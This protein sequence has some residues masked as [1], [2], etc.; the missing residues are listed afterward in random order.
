MDSCA[1]GHSITS[2]PFINDLSSGQRKTEK[3][4]DWL[5]LFR[6]AQCP[7]AWRKGERWKSL[8]F[9]P[10]PRHGSLRWVD[11]QVCTMMLF[12][13]FAFYFLLIL[14]WLICNSHI[15]R[16]NPHFNV[17]VWYCSNGMQTC[18]AAWGKW[19][20]IWRKIDPT[21]T[22]PRTSATAPGGCNW[23]RP[24]GCRS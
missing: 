19:R 15:N 14:K 7:G 11:W 4:T 2:R 16:T 12:Y 22:W 10:C 8:C 1:V 24:R 13:L 18:L 21:W 20:C 17:C 9:R 3:K 6:K 23:R 5:D